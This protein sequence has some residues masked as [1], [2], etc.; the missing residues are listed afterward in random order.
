[1]PGNLAPANAQGS[2]GQCCG[3]D[4]QNTNYCCPPSYSA[5]CKS[6]SYSPFGYYCQNT[7]STPTSSGLSAGAVIGIAF[8]AIIAIAMCVFCARRRDMLLRQQPQVAYV[9]A[10]QAPVYAAPG[11]VQPHQGYVQPGYPGQQQQVI[12]GQPQPA[13]VY[14]QPQ[15]TVIVA[16]GGY[17]YGYNDGGSSFVSGMIVGEAL[18]GGFGHHHHHHHGDGAFFFFHGTLNMV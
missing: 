1:L 15:P 7:P 12:Y 9:S 10:A 6:N 4:T 14:A 18:S 13:V 16:N 17:G 11:Y 8:A 3:K 5:T 2:P